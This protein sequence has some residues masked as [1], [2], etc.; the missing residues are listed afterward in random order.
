[1]CD[2]DCQENRQGEDREEELLLTPR[3][4]SPPK[5]QPRTPTKKRVK[6]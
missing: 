4:L 5:K 1:M 2:S 6:Q 3:K